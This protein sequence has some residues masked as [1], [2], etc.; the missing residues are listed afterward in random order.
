MKHKLLTIAAC[1]IVALSL[2]A[3]AGMGGGSGIPSSGNGITDIGNPNEDA[4]LVAT[5][6]VYINQEFEVRIDYPLRWELEERNSYEANFH[7]NKGE[8]IT[9]S[10]VELED[11]DNLESFLAE[12]RGGSSDLIEKNHP[13]FDRSLCVD[14]AIVGGMIAIEC[15][16]YRTDGDFVMTFT[17]VSITTND[18]PSVGEFTEVGLADKSSSTEESGMTKIGLLDEESEEE[19]E[20]FIKVTHCVE[21]DELKTVTLRKPKFD[22]LDPVNS[23]WGS[24]EPLGSPTI[25]TP[26]RPGS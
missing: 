14:N 21:K 6:G 24:W 11:G 12:V 3:C 26:P 22:P 4:E 18:A 25:Q 19:S 1:L 9:A 17:G 23:S 5:K 15:Y 7:S 10:F 20:G 8:S 13:D 2:S 16:Y